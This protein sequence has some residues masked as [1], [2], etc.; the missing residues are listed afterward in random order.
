MDARK[1]STR[2]PT[3]V[4]KVVDSNVQKCYTHFDSVV[5]LIQAWLYDSVEMTQIK[6]P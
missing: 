6:P 2:V 4:Y 3:L 1:D 5:T